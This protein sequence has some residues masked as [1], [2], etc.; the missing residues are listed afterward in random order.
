MSRI[1]FSFCA[2][3]L[4]CHVRAYLPLNDTFENPPYFKK[5]IF[6]RSFL[7]YVL[8]FDIATDIAKT[9]SDIGLPNRSRFGMTGNEISQN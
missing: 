1:F 7:K 3:P 8:N 2:L 5:I 9:E 6:G 4:L